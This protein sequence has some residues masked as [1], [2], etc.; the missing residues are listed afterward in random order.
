MTTK[1]YKFKVFKVYYSY[2][3]HLNYKMNGSV[4]ILYLFFPLRFAFSV[5]TIVIYWPLTTTD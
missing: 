5:L 1:D 3:I 2:K 4:R